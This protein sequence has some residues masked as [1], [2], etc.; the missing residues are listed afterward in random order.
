M[1][2]PTL[3][4]IIIAFFWTGYFVLEGFDFGV[5]TLLHT[6]APD[7]KA[8]TTMLRTIAPVW[9]GNEVWLIVAAG[10]TFAAIP[11]W[12]AT[13]FSAFYLPMLLILV[14]LI[15]RALGLEYRNKHTDPTWRRRW[16][17]AITIGSI[18]PA[19]TWGLVIANMTNGIPI[20]ADGVYTGTTLDL[21][22]PYAL[23]GAA[24]T[25][26][27]FSAH[28]AVF[29]A[30]KTTS[31]LRTRAIS[32]ADILA[33]L[34]FPVAAVFLAWT[35][36]RADDTVVFGLALTAIAVLGAA[37][38]ANK[39][40]REGWA[41]AATSVAIAATVAVQFTA[42]FPAVMPSSLAPEWS[43]TV[44]SAASSPYTLTVMTVVALIV[45][46][47]VLAYQAW[48]YWVFRQ[49]LTQEPVGV[50]DGAQYPVGEPDYSNSASRASTAASS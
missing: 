44:A 38:A 20:N 46:P 33:P 9:D 17:L 25:T 8:R 16:D 40:R 22:G 12:Y 2:L 42:A 50:A 4:F 5:G 23:L 39:K 28:G 11:A 45:T 3:W 41:F 47:M 30:L 29:T 34:A 26:I 14:A 18:A 35:A 27:L 15:I 37:V 1:D 24:T 31:T 49:R 19:A 21:F 7:T 32:A 13:L 43:L 6:I 36:I 48:T 10:A